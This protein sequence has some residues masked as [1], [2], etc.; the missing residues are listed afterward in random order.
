MRIVLLMMVALGALAQD[1]QPRYQAGWP[2]TGKE[3]AFDPTY[4]K[5][6][7]ATGG[8][9]FLF[10][11]SEVAGT[12]ALAIG[13][14][15]H[16]DTIVRRSGK[17]ESYLDIPIPVDASIDSLFVVASLQCMQTILLY[18]PQRSSVT[19]DADADH[20]FRAGRIA[21]IVKPAAGE[22][23][24][25]LA[26]TGAYSVA[27]EAHASEGL[28]GVEVREKTLSLRVSPEIASPQFRLVGP[29]G[30]AIQ[31]LALEP[32]PDSP[33]RF[34]GAFQAG[35]KQF[36]VLVENG[37]GFQRVDARLFENK[38]VQ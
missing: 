21:T 4:S 5:I 19:R 11:K 3:R 9:L 31:T 33:G 15:R 26:G 34:S 7:E 37:A 10:D 12:S 27:V 30:E 28:R 23:L 2:C 22:W 29:V 8:H 35:A 14:T 32:D 24:L 13:D 1:Q 17:L 38:S 16:K 36:R 6:A 18:D 25:R 20:W